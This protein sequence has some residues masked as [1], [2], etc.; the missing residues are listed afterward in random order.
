MMTSLLNLNHS[1]NIKIMTKFQSKQNLLYRIINRLALKIH[2]NSKPN[3]VK[4]LFI[5]DNSIYELEEYNDDD[6]YGDDFEDY[7]SDDELWF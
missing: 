2:F 3:S 4:W 7:Q 6:E 1:N 5:V